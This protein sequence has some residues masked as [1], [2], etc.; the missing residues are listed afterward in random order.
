MTKHFNELVEMSFHKVYGV[1]LLAA[2]T[3]MLSN[4]A[5]LLSGGEFNVVSYHGRVVIVG[6]HS[7]LLIGYQREPGV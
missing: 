5:L 7:D 4:R 6:V 1:R 2:Q 3:D